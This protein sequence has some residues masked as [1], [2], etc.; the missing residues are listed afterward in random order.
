MPPR[1]GSD[2]HVDSAP[3]ASAWFRWD[4]PLMTLVLLV[5]FFLSA[6]LFCTSML[7]TATAMPNNGTETC[8]GIAAVDQVVLV[9]VDAMRPDFVLSALRKYAREDGGCLPLA[10]SAGVPD[11]YS[12]P[13]LRY[14]QDAIGDPTDASHGFFLVADA[15]TTTGQRIKAIATGTMPAFLE[16]GSNFN[17]E[18]TPLDSI[19]RQAG[20]RAVFLGDDTWTK[21]FPGRQHWKQTVEVPSFDVADFHTNDD[22]VL[23]KIFGVLTKETTEG[24]RE[25]EAS[26]APGSENGG[27]YAKLIVAHFLGIDHVG[28]RINAANREMDAKIAQ[29]NSMLHNVSATLRS[30]KTRMNTM[31]LMLGDH[32]MMQSGDHGGDSPLE[33]DTFLFAQYFRGSAHFPPSHQRPSDLSAMTAISPAKA[34]LKNRVAAARAE[35]KPDSEL[36]RLEAC[37]AVA[38]VDPTQL[39]AAYQVD[40]APTVSVLLGVPIPYSSFG[41]VIPEV[42]ALADEGIDLEEVNQCNER[43]IMRYFREAALELPAH[44]PWLDTRVTTLGQKLAAMSF[45]ARR[46]RTDMNLAGMAAGFGAICVCALSALALQ[47]VQSL[48]RRPSAVVAIGVGVVILRWAIPLG[49]SYIVHED[50]SLFGLATFYALVALCAHRV[51]ANVS[52]SKAKGRRGLSLIRLLFADTALLGCLVVT[53]VSRTAH[54]YLLKRRFHISHAVESESLL[55]AAVRPLAWGPLGFL[56]KR[57]GVLAGLL[58]WCFVSRASATAAGRRAAPM[59]SVAALAAMSGLAM[60]LAN[61]AAVVHHLVPVA[62]AAGFALRRRGSSGPTAAAASPREYAYLMLVLWIASLCNEQVVPSVV[63]AVYGVLLP[64]LVAELHR[65]DIHP[66]VQAVLLHLVSFAIFFMQGHQCLLSTIDWNAS[67]VGMPGYSMLFGGVLVVTRT[68]NAFL[69]LP[70][71]YTVA[72]KAALGKRSAVGC[73]SSAYVRYLLLEL[74]VVEAT[75]SAFSAFLQRNHLMLLPIFCPKL[76]FD[77]VI[78]LVTG[79]AVLVS[80]I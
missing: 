48:L 16:A 57:M 13:T 59:L 14:L 67:F 36:T 10:R 9:L 41:R 39:G 26:V 50:E 1:P 15:P 68:F 31:L 17:S 80:Y 69:L 6:L 4:Y 29:L 43:Q 32:G 49:N 76:I 64:P 20:G 66:A 38:G 33:T 65:L 52:R 21:L 75:M 3:K 56:L 47:D 11:M 73:A 79:A 55:D 71:A 63:I 27:L 45:W 78:C 58:L 7:S 34:A 77:V 19:I 46:T 28:H 8:R 62:L 23:R 51:G 44:P 12:G 61:G 42:L 5:A 74:M 35:E 24:D 18:A 22:A 40:V 25:R 54:P 53:A 60:C 37:R 70:I 30:R 2:A 72:G